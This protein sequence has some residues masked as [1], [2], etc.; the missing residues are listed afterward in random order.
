MEQTTEI[1][2][3][4]ILSSQAHHRNDTFGTEVLVTTRE[5]VMLFRISLQILQISTKLYLKQLS[6]ACLSRKT[7][8]NFPY[9]IMVYSSRL[10]WRWG[11]LQSS[12]V[13]GCNTAGMLWLTWNGPRATFLICPLYARIPSYGCRKNFVT[14][15]PFWRIYE[16]N[17]LDVV[18][19]KTADLEFQSSSAVRCRW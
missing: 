14:R 19:S 18:I 13:V 3:N 15:S 12:W 2:T 4:K 1:Q 7:W 5:A 10:E 8:R 9:I 6:T 17:Q 11:R 16:D